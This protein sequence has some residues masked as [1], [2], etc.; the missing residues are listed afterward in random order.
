LALFCGERETESLR[1]NSAFPFMI[2]VAHRG[3]TA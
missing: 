2:Q 3:N 1:Q